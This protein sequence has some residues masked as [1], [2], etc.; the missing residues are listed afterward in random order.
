VTSNMIFHPS[1]RKF[2]ARW[3]PRIHNRGLAKG[4]PRLNPLF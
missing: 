2:G 1:K 3:G 4:E